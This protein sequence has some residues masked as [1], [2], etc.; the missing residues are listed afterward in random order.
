M[1]GLDTPRDERRVADAVRRAALADELILRNDTFAI[2]RAGAR[3]GWGVAVVAGAGMNGLGVG[4]NGRIARFAGLGDISG[5]WEG[6]GWAALSASVRGRDGRGPRT[7]LERLVPAH[8]GL[9]RPADLTLALYRHRFRADRVRELAPVVYAAAADGDAVA[10]GIVRLLADEIAAFATAAIRRTGSTRREVDIVLAGGLVRSRDPLLLAGVE[11]RVHAMAP[12]ARLVV[13]DRPPVVGAALLGLDRLASDGR[14]APDVE[15]R[16]RNGL[17][18]DR[19][20]SPAPA[21]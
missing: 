7:S 9:R 1:A 5:D 18:D 14:T 10:L 16:L 13:L 6:V 12:R 3:S 4:L 15:A 19:L 17:T 20:A 8:F 21:T 11:E 2:L